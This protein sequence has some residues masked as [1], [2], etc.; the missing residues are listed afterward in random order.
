MAAPR[1]TAF[2]RPL[3][4]LAL[5]AA[6]SACATTAS[7]PV[8]TT[9]PPAAVVVGIP[10]NDNLN[11][12]LWQQQSVEYRLL[13]GQTYRSALVQLDRAIKDPAW[14]A[15]PE[16]DREGPLQRGLPMAV[17]VDVDET[18]LDNSA[19]QA[20][21]VVRDLAYDEATWDAWVR[22]QAAPA[23]PGAL[24]FLQ[25]AAK[26]GV[27]VFYVSNR[28]QAQAAPTLANLQALGFPTADDAHF[29]GKGA[30]VAGCTGTGSDKGCRRRQV[31]RTHRVLMQIG[32]QL[33]DFVDIADNSPAG[34]EAA[35]SA[36]RGWV[37]E[38]WFVL[39]N[40]TY[41][42]WEPAAFGNQ[43]TLPEAERRRL[44]RAAL[45]PAA[46]PTTTSD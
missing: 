45:R 42:S 29:F 35:V 16:A 32:D 8:A 27:E 18:V 37:G 30:V 1:P 39:P 12:V 43:W 2:A 31:G 33:G 22:Q 10:A 28:T 23:V 36:Y 46:A 14:D 40:P 34:R 19:Y 17:I 13:A 5:I 6:L 4:S 21:L 44:K 9:P 38:R 41:G 15:L 7:T 11:A 26:R 20:G 25:N 3:L 24:P